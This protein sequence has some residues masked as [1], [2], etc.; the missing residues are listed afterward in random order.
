[1]PFKSFRE[2]SKEDWGEI[3]NERVCPTIEQINAGCLMRIADASEKMAQRHTELI[4]QRDSFERRY[5]T[6]QKRVE[7]L[8]R[9]NASLRGH[10]KRAKAKV[11]NE[12]LSAAALDTD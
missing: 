4:E 8:E 3:S 12:K 7:H 5:K 6:E 1:M 10:L 9:S 2:E 11:S